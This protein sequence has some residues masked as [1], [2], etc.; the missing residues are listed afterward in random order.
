MENYKIAIP[1]YKRSG[2][3]K[4][5]TLNYLSRCGVDMDN[6]Y[7]F[8]SN[9]KEADEYKES[10]AGI[11]CRVICPLIDIN[12]VTEKFNY[13]HSYF[14]EGT[15][16]FVMEDDIKNLVRIT[17]NIQCTKPSVCENLAFVRVGFEY[18]RKANT[19]LFGIAPHNNGFYMSYNVSTNLK[20]IV[21]HAYGFISDHSRDLF[22]TQI[23]KSDYE[24]SIL[25][26][27]KFGSVVRF[28]NIGVTTNSYTTDGGMDRD[29]RYEHE[30]DSCNY[31]VTRYP[32]FIKYNKK[33]KSK[34]PELLFN[35]VVQDRAYW[36][37]IQEQRDMELGYVT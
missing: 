7:V 30:R 1:S 9:K 15:N 35:R 36:R 25:Y 16:V 4:E 28:N 12:T 2:I 24:R 11:G 8:T 10:T 27:L 17:A 23:G 20:L 5:R 29:G 21:A 3:I 34:Y 22:V 13:I 19:K 6:V 37:V 32:H 14:S 26:F 33:K 18:C 31:L